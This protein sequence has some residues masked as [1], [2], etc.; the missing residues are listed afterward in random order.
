M[1]QIYVVG[2]RADA[3]SAERASRRVSVSNGVPA[4][5][6]NA[7]ICNR[8]ADAVND[9]DSHQG[10][11]PVAPGSSDPIELQAP[12]TSGLAQRLDPS[13]PSTATTTASRISL[14]GL[15][16]WRASLGI[17]ADSRCA[18]HCFVISAASQCPAARHR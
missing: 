6:R 10:P 13:R 8:K 17:H 5:R 11:A 15:R 1:N 14:V 18:I 3:R 7:R 4:T 12:N 9:E 2:W 16:R